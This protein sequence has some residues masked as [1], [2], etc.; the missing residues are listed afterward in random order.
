V[1]QVRD[2]GEKY[3]SEHFAALDEVWMNPER[4]TLISEELVEVRNSFHGFE[5]KTVPQLVCRNR[6]DRGDILASNIS[7]KKDSEGGK[8]PDVIGSYMSLAYS[9]LNSS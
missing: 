5:L 1:A 2:E 9:L 7:L 8:G 3:V 6:V 4:F